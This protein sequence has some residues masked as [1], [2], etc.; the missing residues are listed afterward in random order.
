MNLNDQPQFNYADL[1]LRDAMGRISPV[2]GAPALAAII[3]NARALVPKL[4]A[5]AE[6]TEAARRVSTQTTGEFREAGFF[7]LM[8][9]A[10]FGGY[11]YGF[12]AFIDIISELGRGC[13][14]SAWGC[15]LGAIHQ[16]LLGTMPLEAQNDV[17][18]ENPDAILCGSYAP[19]VKAVAADGGFLVE[20]KW[21][22]ASNVDNSDWA[23]LG[24]MFPADD[25]SPAPYP[26]FLM[27]P[28]KDWDIED[29]WFVAGQAGTG[30]KTIVVGQPLFI[31]AHRKIS[32]A[33]LSSNAPPGSAHNLNPVYRIPFLSAVPVCLVSPLLGT[34]QGAVDEFIAMAGSRVTRG[35]V[36]GGGNR[37]CDFF[38]VQSRLAEAAASLDAAR[39]LIYRDTAEVES[40]AA[41]GQI[42]S[43]AQRIRNRRN[44]AYAARLSRDAVECLFASVG[45]AGLATSQPIQRMWRDANAIAKHISLNWDAVS[46]MCGQHMLGLE[47]KGQY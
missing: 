12:T 5:R 28:R 18:G 36:S 19:A 22:W 42:I 13:T 43:V 2:A 23:L 45:G 41:S 15:S 33:E 29:T 40:I 20:G 4:K 14:S 17:W 34:A 16:W 30:S 25:T 35:A 47:P 6:A 10:R 3:D 37:M 9:P 31:P 26:G 27:A 8:Q 46:S 38:P 7:K 44:H 11:E 24:V 39:L 32:F 1:G 21:H